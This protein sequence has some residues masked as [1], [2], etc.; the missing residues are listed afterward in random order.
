MDSFNV[1]AI[2]HPSG[3]GDKLLLGSTQGALKLWKVSNQKSIYWFKGF[4]SPVSC[5]AQAPA[6]DVCAIGL[7]NGQIVLH[8][9]R[10][11]MPLVSVSQ[12]GGAVTTIEFRSGMV[13]I[14]YHNI[15]L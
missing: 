5:L 15:A 2:F 11:D 6:E 8:N 1:S 13:E 9:L 4:D 3:Y 14:N 12:D 7:G 10:Y